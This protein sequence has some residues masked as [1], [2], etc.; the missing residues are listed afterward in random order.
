MEPMQQSRELERYRRRIGFSQAFVN[1]S[2]KV[3][4]FVDED[5]EVTVLLDMEH[6]MTLRYYVTT[7][8]LHDLG[9][10]GSIF[11]WWN[12]RA[13]EDCIF[14]RLDRVLANM[15]FQ[16]LFPG[17]EITHLSKI[18]S[19]HSPSLITFDPNFVLGKKQFRFLNFWTDH[20][21]FQEV[22]KENRKISSLEEVVLV[23]EA[24]FEINP[25]KL[26]RE[27]LH[28]VQAELISEGSWIKGNEQLAAEAVNFYQAQFHEDAIPTAFGIINHVPN[29]VTVEQNQDFMKQPTKYEVKKA[30]FRLN[31][32]SARGPDGFTGKC[33]HCCW[34]IIGYDV[35]NM[36]RQYFNGDDLPNL[37]LT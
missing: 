11:T 21:T 29:M 15:E 19:D 10:K 31:G 1:I 13:K 14:K 16:Q 5:Y 2:N 35:Y 30:M 8:K 25:T 26:N 27:R 36:V 6:Q 32:V 7:C 17:V 23:P 37:L 28:K 22:V 9:F 24:S 34:D 4:A 3:W 12:G 18:G 33:F 20:A